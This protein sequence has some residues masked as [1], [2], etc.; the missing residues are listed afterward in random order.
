MCAAA[1]SPAEPLTG[2]STAVVPIAVLTVFTPNDRNEK[3]TGTPTAGASTE[4]FQ[5]C[6][7]TS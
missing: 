5:M 4:P 2:R 7:M 6:A 1:G 3:R